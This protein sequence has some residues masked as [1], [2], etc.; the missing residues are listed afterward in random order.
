[1]EARIRYL[2][3]T[4]QDPDALARFYSG[5]LGLTE[6]GRSSAGD[7]SLTDGYYN[8]TLLHGRPEL[9]GPDGEFGVN[10]FGFAID[11][12][13]DVEARLEEFGGN[14]DLQPES[15]DLHHG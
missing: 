13:H 1:M 10:H 8:L 4:C 9:T 12:V 7:V 14:A 11:D 6:L 2:A 3:I 5:H 15:G